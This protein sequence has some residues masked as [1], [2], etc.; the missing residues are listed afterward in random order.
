MAV[1]KLFATVLLA[2]CAFSATAAAA[3]TLNGSAPS[4]TLS[5]DLSRNHSPATVGSP[6][7]VVV[8]VDPSS[9]QGS[10]ALSAAQ[11]RARVGCSPSPVHH[12]SV[13]CPLNFPVSGVWTLTATHRAGT[14]VDASRS[15]TL[16]VN[17]K[18]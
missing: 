14:R 7:L 13:T 16:R 10:V 18:G 11:G 12:H 5:F 17:A 4:P 3:E 6:F 8:T 15:L 2:S 1:R 9:L